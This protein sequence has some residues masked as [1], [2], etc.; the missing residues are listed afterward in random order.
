MND[1]QPRATSLT[2]AYVV[3]SEVN[4][5][6]N[7]E[8]S[9]HVY[10]L[11][12]V[13]DA[14]PI[15]IL[16]LAD[17]MGGHE[18]GEVVSYEA[19]RKASLVLFELLCVQPAINRT[20]PE[21]SITEDVLA[22]ALYSAIEQTNAHVRRMVQTNH[23]GT[24][25]STIVIAAVLGD[26]CIAA[27]L[28]DS[29]LFHYQA[30]TGELHRVTDDHTVA[31]V[32]L[33]AGAITPEMARYHEGRSRL[34][35]YLGAEK[36]PRDKPLYTMKL[37]PGDRLLLCSDG[38][39]GQLAHNDVQA[40]FCDAP[41]DLPSL[42]DHL[43]EAARAAGE[44]DNQ[45]L[46][47]WQYGARMPHAT[48]I[49]QPAHTD[50]AVPAAQ[51]APDDS[52]HDHEPAPDP[53]P[54]GSTASSAESPDAS[55]TPSPADGVPDIAPVPAGTPAQGDAPGDPAILADRPRAAGETGNQT[56]ILQKHGAQPP[57]ATETAPPVPAH[58]AALA[59]QP[60]PDNSTHDQEP[61]ADPSG[62][63]PLSNEDPDAGA[64][65]SP[66][67]GMPDTAPAP[68]NMPAREERP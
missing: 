57:D 33:R 6:E 8:D 40:C 60:A 36:L 28:G 54:S 22:H 55:A 27:N 11:S 10:R 51:P 20:R 58:T 18:H 35:F 26:T 32:L 47:L 7:N 48:K 15:W 34:E 3:R 49:A 61:A 31:G 12:C 59:A 64:A 2:G 38:V 43:I 30:T 68:A 56:P 63:S 23:W 50:A 66:A 14:D 21:A 62:A 46:I 4:G 52:T 44:T 19:L 24:A 45:T 65:P 17:G 67:D 25:G 13:A 1:H 37:A 53:A 16:A 9:F 5:R 29:P 42:A 41:G 39:T